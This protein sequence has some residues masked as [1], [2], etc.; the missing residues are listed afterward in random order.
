[1]PYLVKFTL[2]L[3]YT[4]TIYSAIQR[5]RCYFT[6]GGVLGRKIHV[7]ELE[8]VVHYPVEFLHNLNP[9]EIPPHNLYLKIGAPK[10]YCNTHA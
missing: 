6:A 3:K 2:F 5:W 4:R 8:D 10:R 1:M 9:P 7:V